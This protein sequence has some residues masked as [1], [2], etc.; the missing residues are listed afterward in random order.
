LIDPAWPRPYHSMPPLD[1][2][3]GMTGNRTPGSASPSISDA[4]GERGP[5]KLTHSA[6]PAR[7]FCAAPSR[8]ASELVAT[9]ICE[10]SLDGGLLAGRII[11]YRQTAPADI[12]AVTHAHPALA[13]EPRRGRPRRPSR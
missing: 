10:Q 12:A 5:D 7:R 1:G 3:E 4:D 9:L 8:R 11:R 6:F 2:G 13:A